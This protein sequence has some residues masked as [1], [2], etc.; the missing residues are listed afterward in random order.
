MRIMAVGTLHM[1]V[2]QITLSKGS[3]TLNKVL[4]IPIHTG[5]TNV[6]YL[7]ATWLIDRC[8]GHPPR[9]RKVGFYIRYLGTK[10]LTNQGTTVT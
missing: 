8:N 6:M 5:I 1:A 10:T 7:T 4:T 3:C 9:Q 2:H